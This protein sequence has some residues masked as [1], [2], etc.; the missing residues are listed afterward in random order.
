MPF[1][2]RPSAAYRPADRPR[3]SR[4]RF[5]SNVCDNRWSRTRHIPVL[6]IHCTRAIC[7]CLDLVVH[8]SRWNNRRIRRAASARNQFWGRSP[9]RSTLSGLVVSGKGSAVCGAFPT[10]E[11]GDCRA[12]S[13]RTAP[14]KLLR[15][16]PRRRK[17]AG[18]T[19]LADYSGPT[20]RSQQRCLAGQPRSQQRCW[21][22]YLPPTRAPLLP[23]PCTTD[24]R[25]QPPASD[26]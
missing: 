2:A 12:D 10:A 20:P 23:R 17:Q 7:P 16:L 21:Q 26:I 4:V 3:T 11:E 25:A 24:R 1:H 8:S 18:P 6:A 19:K 22:R 5:H 15:Q 9:P 13:R 14:G